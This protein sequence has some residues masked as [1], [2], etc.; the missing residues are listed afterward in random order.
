M[1]YLGFNRS[2][3][4]PTRQSSWPKRDRGGQRRRGGGKG[5]YMGRQGR[6]AAGRGAE[7]GTDTDRRHIVDTT[8][9]PRS[10]LLHPPLSPLEC[11]MH[12]ARQATVETERED[13]LTRPLEDRTRVFS[14]SR[15]HAL[16]A[17]LPFVCVER[18]SQWHRLQMLYPT[19]SSASYHLCKRRRRTAWQCY[20]TVPFDRLNAREAIRQTSFHRTPHGRHSYQGCSH[21]VSNIE[22]FALAL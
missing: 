3:K 1:S 20:H 2:A 10:V 19:A 15:L 14:V 16:V 7:A 22:F 17:K 21:R 12:A 6:G 18:R 11:P 8:A 9:P 5:D 4:R 13:G